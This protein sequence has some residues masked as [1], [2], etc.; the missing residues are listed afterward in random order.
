M[1]GGDGIGQN[2]AL[3]SKSLLSHLITSLAPRLFVR[4]LVF[5]LNYVDSF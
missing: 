5:V 2:L 3:T 4:S 1:Q